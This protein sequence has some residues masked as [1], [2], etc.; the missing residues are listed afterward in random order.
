VNENGDKVWEFLQLLN[1]DIYIYHHGF[2]EEADIKDVYKFNAEGSKSLFQ[3]LDQSGFTPS[4][5]S[6]I[7]LNRAVIAA[8]WYI[9]DESETIKDL[10]KLFPDTFPI[11]KQ[12][13]MDK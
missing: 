1:G 11:M 6:T 9:S 5:F 7:R 2:K 13:E 12:E 8:A 3:R 4:K 10:K